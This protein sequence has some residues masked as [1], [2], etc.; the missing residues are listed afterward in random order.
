MIWFYEF[1]FQFVMLDILIG[2][3]CFIGMV[4]FI[5]KLWL[6]VIQEFKFEGGLEDGYFV[7]CVFGL[8]CWYIFYVVGVL[9]VVFK[10]MKWYCK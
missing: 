9:I 6:G 2:Q 8:G 10:F 7:V 5:I 1:N 4:F 3:G